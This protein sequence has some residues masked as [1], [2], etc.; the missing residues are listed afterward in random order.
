MAETGDGP[1]SFQVAGNVWHLE[2]GNPEVSRTKFSIP[3]DQRLC[4][5]GYMC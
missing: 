2:Y 4:H 5:F 3:K 1:G